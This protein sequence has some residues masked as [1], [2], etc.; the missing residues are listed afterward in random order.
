[1]VIPPNPLKDRQLRRERKK[2][3]RDLQRRLIAAYPDGLPYPLEGVD[4]RSLPLPILEDFF[5]LEDRE[6]ETLRSLNE[7]GEVTHIVMGHDGQPGVFDDCPVCQKMQ[8][9]GL[10]PDE[11]G[12]VRMSWAQSQELLEVMAE[13]EAAQEGLW[14]TQT[15]AN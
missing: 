5:E 4:P 11:H 1:M 10:E 13:V 12:Q 2:R 14:R 6:L 9:M 3:A 8:E 15:L 7:Q